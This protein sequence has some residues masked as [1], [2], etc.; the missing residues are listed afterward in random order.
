MLDRL[1]SSLVALSLALL[2]WLYLRSRDQEM[3]DNVPIPVQVALARGQAEHYELEVNGGGE[4]PVSFT[5]PPSRIRELRNLLQRGALEVKVTLNVPEDRLKEPRFNDTVR[6]EANDIHPPPGVTPI[7]SEGRN[8]VSVTLHRIVE[9]VVPVHFER[10]P[11]DRIA[12]AEIDPPTV[13]VRG[14]QEVVDRLRSIPTQPYGLPSRPDPVA[15]KATTLTVQVP[16]AQEVEGRAV[17]TSPGAVAVHLTIQP[18]QKVH[19]LIDVPIHFL[20]PPN[21]PLRPLFHDE[22][23]GKITLRLLGPAAEEPP[24]VVAYIDLSGRKWDAGLYEEP[25]RLHLPRDF[26]PAPNQAPPK[27]VPFRLDVPTDMNTPKGVGIPP[28]R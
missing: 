27:N 6:V 11:E 17:R 3:L 10:A 19:E 23:A 15:G 1:I 24:A 18:Q 5:G 21:F 9:R 28:A 4:I 2:V 12:K 16:L 7:V 20:C 8:R 13:L 14:P 25:L 26:Q 22:R